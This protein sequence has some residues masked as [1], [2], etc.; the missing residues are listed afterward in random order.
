MFNPIPMPFSWAEL[1]LAS[2]LTENVM[3]GLIQFARYIST[4]IALRY[5]TF[6]PHNYSFSSLRRNEFLFTSS[7]QT[8]IGELIGCF[9]AKEKKKKPIWSTMPAKH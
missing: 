9:L 1:Y 6:G 3:F 4:S 8:T 7:E 2:R 5:D